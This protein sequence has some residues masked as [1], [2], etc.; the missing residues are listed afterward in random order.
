[1]I[2]WK[3]IP[4]RLRPRNPL[5]LVLDYARK[6][7]FCKG[8][9]A[10][11]GNQSI[12]NASSWIRFASSCSRVVHSG[13]HGEGNFLRER[14]WDL[15]H[16]FLMHSKKGEEIQGC[17]WCKLWKVWH[18]SP[19]PGGC[20]WICGVDSLWW[21]GN[22][23]GAQ[24]SEFSGSFRGL[25]EG[26]SPQK[27]RC[28]NSPIDTPFLRSCGTGR[29]ACLNRCWGTWWVHDVLR[30]AAKNFCL[31]VFFTSKDLIKK[32]EF[33]I[34]L[35][36]IFP[37]ASDH[38]LYFLGVLQ[39]PSSTG[40]YHSSSLIFP[41]FHCQRC[42][43]DHTW[44]KVGACE[45]LR[46]HGDWKLVPLEHLDHVGFWFGEIPASLME[47]QCEDFRFSLFIKLG[48]TSAC[49]PAEGTETI[50]PGLQAIYQNLRG[51]MGSLIHRLFAS[52]AK[53]PFAMMY[54]QGWWG[55]TWQWGWKKR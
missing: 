46:V 34:L 31:S 7:Q 15:R 40:N 16:C 39:I 2:F 41:H 11:K 27:R 26:Q 48:R 49:F 37:C 1:M 36:K 8:W 32:R 50:I 6:L 21:S 28:T 10:S 54:F 51:A 23:E 9:R 35:W 47:F 18:G 53:T 24:W 12:M 55:G 42:R 17:S 44:P 33:H 20:Q 38:H 22:Q 3:V 19:Y 52:E 30:S 4:S 43:P 5:R 25:M 45:H 13:S 29:D 14:E